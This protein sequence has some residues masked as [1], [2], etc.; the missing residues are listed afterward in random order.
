V[1]DADGMN[2]RPGRPQTPVP[3]LFGTRWHPLAANLLASCRHADRP[4]LRVGWPMLS[5]SGRC[6]E[7]RLGQRFCRLLASSH[8][9]HDVELLVLTDGGWLMTSALPED[10]RRAVRWPPGAVTA[11]LRAMF[12]LIMG[13]LFPGMGSASPPIAHR[14]WR[15]GWG[16]G[17][18]SACAAGAICTSCLC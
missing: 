9:I 10:S 8:C 7:R 11:A 6:A 12:E 14:R 3:S 18:L 15:R 4:D 16:R 2:R 13:R 17:W 5:R 1:A